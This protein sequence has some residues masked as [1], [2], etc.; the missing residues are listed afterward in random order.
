MK[1]ESRERLSQII[2]S[3]CA[4]SQLPT[5]SRLMKFFNV[6]YQ[7]QLLRSL[8][9][10]I[11][12]LVSFSKKVTTSFSLIPLIFLFQA[13]RKWLLSNSYQ[14]H[15]NWKGKNSFSLWIAKQNISKFGWQKSVTT[16]PSQW[17]SL[18]KHSTG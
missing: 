12:G 14:E 16:N 8:Q 3:F 11:K 17:I 2:I 5:T 7:Y 15:I 13:K 1:R 10:R 6:S 18:Q 9:K 4:Q